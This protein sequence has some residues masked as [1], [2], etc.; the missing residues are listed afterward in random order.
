MRREAGGRVYRA[1]DAKTL[2][3]GEPRFVDREPDRNHIAVVPA[4]S[5]DG[6][7]LAIPRPAGR[8]LF[9]ELATGH[10]TSV[11]NQRGDGWQ[12][13]AWIPGTTAVLA[14]SILTADHAAGTPRTSGVDNRVDRVDMDGSVAT[15][16]DPTTGFMMALCPSRDGS[17]A[18]ITHVAPMISELV[19]DIDRS[20][21]PAR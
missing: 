18:V 16:Y 17:R 15:V 21:N 14:T 11:E 4:L 20:R 2:S 6:H 9:V 7:L 5:P 3:I 12:T 1:L 10:V 13:A 8:M 19:F